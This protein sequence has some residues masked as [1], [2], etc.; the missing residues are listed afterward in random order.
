MALVIGTVRTTNY[1]EPPQVIISPD[2]LITERILGLM[3]DKLP[4]GVVPTL[5]SDLV[6]DDA[7]TISEL[8]IPTPRSIQI[9]QMYA[10]IELDRQSVTTHRIDHLQHGDMDKYMEEYAQNLTMAAVENK[11]EMMRRAG[12]SEDEAIEAIKQIR[13][14]KAIEIAGRRAPYNTADEI[15]K[16]IRRTE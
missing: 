6:S 10:K 16:S 8:F 1:V 13:A 7:A 11:V 5:K 4:P 2:R 3:V 14:K 9:E 12:Y 15:I